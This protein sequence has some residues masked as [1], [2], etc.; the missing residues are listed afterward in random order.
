MPIV[1]EQ[2]KKSSPFEISPQEIGSALRD[3]LS[4]L[5][6]LEK[7]LFDNGMTDSGLLLGHIKIVLL[8]VQQ[9]RPANSG[10]FLALLESAQRVPGGKG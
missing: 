4:A 6:P 2:K 5:R 1:T 7:S 8:L 3:S 10:H 9:G